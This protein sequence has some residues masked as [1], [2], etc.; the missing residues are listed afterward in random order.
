MNKIDIEKDAKRYRW[1]KENCLTTEYVSKGCDDF[2]DSRQKYKIS[3]TLMA[4]SCV[5]SGISFDESIDN[6]INEQNNS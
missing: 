6:E 3:K 4:V 2:Y 1:F 5:N